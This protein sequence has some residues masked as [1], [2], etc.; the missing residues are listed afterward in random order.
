MAV[1]DFNI[2]WQENEE[3]TF[4][5]LIN[6]LISKKVQ[7]GMPQVVAFV[8]K[9]RSGKTMLALK[10]QDI[11]YRYFGLD[12]LQYM[13]QVVFI[14]PSAWP[15]TM[16]PIIRESDKHL[17]KAKSI[18]LDEAKFL[19]NSDNWQKVQN[20]GTR[21][22]IGVSA[23]IQPMLIIIV[24]QIRKDIDPRIRET[25]DLLFEVKRSRGHKPQVKV[26][27]NY[28]KVYDMS[29]IKIMPRALRG[30]V[31]YPNGTHKMVFP[32]FAPSMPRKELVDAYQSFEK[33]DKK[34][35][36]L[37]IV[38]EMRKDIDKLQGSDEKILSLSNLLSQNPQELELAGKWNSKQEKWRLSKEAKKKFAINNKEDVK[39]LEKLVTKQ[40]SSKIIKTEVV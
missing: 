36:L 5:E 1:F 35:Q 34:E 24:A 31:R 11:M 10:I 28:E 15:E 6:N 26:F 33:P 38:K 8:G 19:V 9:S 22:L 17:K 18:H 32:E 12:F 2:E 39:E 16:D 29:N 3:E 20:K 27:T 25:L 21:A 37:K 30:I 23:V 40:L 4:E 7:A 13:K 14:K